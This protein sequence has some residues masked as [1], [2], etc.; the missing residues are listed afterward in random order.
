MSEGKDGDFFRKLLGTSR[1]LLPY[2]QAEDVLQQTERQ[3]RRE[4]VAVSTS[5]GRTQGW[6]TARPDWSKASESSGE[7]MELMSTGAWDI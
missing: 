6:R 7:Q 3:T 1:S 4:E 5:A 2:E